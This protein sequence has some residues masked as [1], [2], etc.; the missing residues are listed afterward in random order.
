MLPLH[1]RFR[2][3]MLVSSWA[4]AL[5]RVRAELLGGRGPA[6]PLREVQSRAHAHARVC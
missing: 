3:Y 2:C 5:T 1:S 6:L 4:V